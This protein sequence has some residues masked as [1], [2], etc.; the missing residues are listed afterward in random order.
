M[1]FRS[2]GV[3]KNLDKSTCLTVIQSMSQ[4]RQHDLEVYL[5]KTRHFLSLVLVCC[6]ATLLPYQCWAVIKYHC[7]YLHAS[8]TKIQHEIT[9]F[10]LAG[11]K[12]DW[13]VTIFSLLQCHT[14]KLALPHSLLLM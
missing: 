13:Q 12:S 3:K 14:V 11:K 1:L 7:D 4:R 9:S 2:H 6:S 10:F 8:D 5:K